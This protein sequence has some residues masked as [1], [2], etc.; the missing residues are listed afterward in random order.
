MVAIFRRGRGGRAAGVPID[1]GRDGAF[2]FVGTP[3]ELNC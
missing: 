1:P 2:E 3:P